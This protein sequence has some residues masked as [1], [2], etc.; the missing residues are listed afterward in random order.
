VRVKIEVTIPYAVIVGVVALV[1]II[2]VTILGL[3]LT[4]DR[5]VDLSLSGFPGSHD[6]AAH[7]PTLPTAL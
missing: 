1:V 4:E 6:H 2:F 3:A 5:S 7:R